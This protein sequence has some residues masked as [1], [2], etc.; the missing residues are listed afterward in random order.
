VAL[1]GQRSGVP[2]VPVVI[3]GT[4]R[5]ATAY[6]SLFRLSR[7]QVVFGKPFTTSDL[8]PADGS[9]RDRHAAMTQAIRQRL[10]TLRTAVESGDIGGRAD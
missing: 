10:A 2:I 5:T 8:A 1:I 6:G 7:A 9:R 4:P 3:T